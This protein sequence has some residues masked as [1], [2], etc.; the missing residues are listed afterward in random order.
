MEVVRLIAPRYPQLNADLLLMGAF[1][2]DIGKVDELISDKGL[3][4]SD[5]GQLVGHLVQGVT[6]LEKPRSRRRN[7]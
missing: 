5:E 1:L 6:I 7:E 4:Y 2:H 3:G